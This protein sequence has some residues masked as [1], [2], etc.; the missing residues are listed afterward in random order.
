MLVS[1]AD[2]RGRALC[3]AGQLGPGFAITGAGAFLAGGRSLTEQ[4]KACQ[5]DLFL[6]SGYLLCSEAPNSSFE[7]ARLYWL[8]PI[9]VHT[10]KM[11]DE[12]NALGRSRDFG[13]PHVTC[14]TLHMIAYDPKEKKY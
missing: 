3:L 7:S 9:L 2:G 6:T 13:A 11:Y 1:C 10:R 5:T 12:R 4:T 14:Y 8:A